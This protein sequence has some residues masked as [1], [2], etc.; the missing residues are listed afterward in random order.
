MTGALQASVDLRN[1]ALLIESAI[2]KLFVFRSETCPGE[3]KGDLKG[4]AEISDDQTTSTTASKM[5]LGAC[6]HFEGML[7]GNHFIGVLAE[8]CVPA[9]C[10]VSK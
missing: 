9:C 4:A 8:P 6:Q 3:F 10:S 7:K 5:S 2:R 1:N